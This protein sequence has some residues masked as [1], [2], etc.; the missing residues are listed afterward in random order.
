MHRRNEFENPRKDAPYELIPAHFNFFTYSLE[1]EFSEEAQTEDPMHMMGEAGEMF[2]F[3]E[4]NTKDRLYSGTL[5]QAWN[6]SYALPDGQPL[7]SSNHLLDPVPGD[8]GPVSGKNQA[9]FSNNLGPTSLTPQSL[10]AAITI[11]QNMLSARGLAIAR[12]AVRLVI[13]SNA[14]MMQ[15]ARE[16]TGTEAAP[17]TADNKTNPEHEAL[18]PYAYRYLTWPS[19]WFVCASKTVLRKGMASMITSHKWQNRVRTWY[20]D[21]N[22]S[23]H[24]VNEFRSTFGP[25]GWRDIVAGQGGGPLGF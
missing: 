2:A 11:L 21:S 19:A 22:N 12:D 7:I 23:W 1:V 9:P 6:P 15:L 20:T 3:S 5:N 25:R 14:A 24:M 4:Q 13:P 18:A 16:I 17:Y 10:N 8:F